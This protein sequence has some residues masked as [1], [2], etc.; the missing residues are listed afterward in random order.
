MEG[1]PTG[2]TSLSKPACL[3]SP[4]R[5]PSIARVESYTSLRPF[6]LSFLITAV[7]GGGRGEMCC[8][9]GNISIR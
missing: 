2:I 4:A 6:T 8:W 1:L 3:L 7:Q 5:G 9:T